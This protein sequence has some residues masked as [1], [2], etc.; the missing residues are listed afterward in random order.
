MK[1]LVEDGLLIILR[2]LREW[3]KELQPE[4]WDV[5]EE[6]IKDHPVLLNRAPTLHRLGIQAFEPV[7]S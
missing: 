7:L 6:V 5:L 4:V 2:V 3:L 1:K